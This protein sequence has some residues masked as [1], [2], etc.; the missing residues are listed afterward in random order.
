MFA[1]ITI[2]VAC[3]L[4]RMAA[5]LRTSESPD[6]PDAFTSTPRFSASICWTSVAICEAEIGA[7]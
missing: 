7:G 1:N 3:P 4:L 2:R 6:V 5:T